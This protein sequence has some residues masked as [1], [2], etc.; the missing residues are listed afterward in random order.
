MKLMVSVFFGEGTFLFRQNEKNT[1]HFFLIWFAFYSARG[2]E[3]IFFPTNVASNLAS[4]SS[5]FWGC[6]FKN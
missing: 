4:A 6:G 3:T 5:V 1:T 2:A